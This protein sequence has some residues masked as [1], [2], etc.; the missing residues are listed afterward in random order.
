MLS[1]EER[2]SSSWNRTSRFSESQDWCR[3]TGG[4]EYAPEKPH[5]LGVQGDRLIVWSL[6]ILLLWTSSVLAW[7]VGGVLGSGLSGLAGHRA[8]CGPWTG[9]DVGGPG[10]PSCWK[11]LPLVRG[12]CGSIK[13]AHM[14]SCSG[15]TG[16][17]PLTVTVTVYYYMQNVRMILFITLS[18]NI[19]LYMYLSIGGESHINM[20]L[21]PLQSFRSTCLRAHSPDARN[22][23]QIPS[24]VYFWRKWPRRCPVQDNG[25]LKA[26]RTWMYLTDAQLVQV[27]DGIRVMQLHGVQMDNVINGA[28]SCSLDLCFRE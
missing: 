17:Y 18:S 14:W 6:P 9:L 16:Q 10:D 25:T 12:S 8:S 27:V 13:W 20:G 19:Q 22:M 11:N 21:S 23:N 4:H 3:S 1:K 5:L 26:T 28:F 2:K 24:Q 15:G 7:L